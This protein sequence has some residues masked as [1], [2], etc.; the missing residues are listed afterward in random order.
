MG[1]VL[2]EN[3]GGVSYSNFL[4]WI[5]FAI[6][7]VGF[8]QFPPI[9]GSV[10]SYVETIDPEYW[11]WMQ[12]YGPMTESPEA[13]VIAYNERTEGVY[14]YGYARNPHPAD[15]P[16]VNGYVTIWYLDNELFYPGLESSII[17]PNSLY[18]DLNYRCPDAVNG[19]PSWE[20]ITTYAVDGSGNKTVTCQRSVSMPIESPIKMPNANNICTRDPAGRQSGLSTP[21]PISVPSGKKIRFETDYTG[22]GPQPL[23][24]TRGYLNSSIFS[25]GMGPNWWHNHMGSITF[26]VWP[27]A[28]IS[29]QA[30]ATQVA[31]SRTQQFNFGLNRRAGVMLPDG[32]VRFFVLKGSAWSAQGNLDSFKAVGAGYAYKAVDDDVVYNFN[33]KGQMVSVVL[34]NGWATTYSYNDK[35]LLDS[36]TNQ[37]DQSLNFVYDG[38][39]LLLQVTTP[40]GG[41][42]GYGY[43]ALNNLTQVSYPDGSTRSF[44]YENSDFPAA[45]T[46]ISVN[47]SRIA[48]YAYN[49]SGKAISTVGVNGVDSYQI[50]YGYDVGQPW[51]SITDPL[52]ITR[53]YSYGT[54]Y[55]RTA[56]LWA[57]A[58]AKLNGDVISRGQD[59]NTGLITAETDYIG[60]NK[61]YSWDANRF[62]LSSMRETPRYAV[63]TAIRTSS[64]TWHPNYRLPLRDFRPGT[65]LSYVYNGQPDPFNGD[66]IANCTPASAL[67]GEGLPLPVLCKKVEQATTDA[68]G[69]AGVN[70]VVNV[71]VSSR[72]WTWTYN[73]SAQVLTSTDPRG[74]VANYT[75]GS[76]GSIASITNAMGHVTTYLA[77]D[78]NGNPL[79]TSD[80]NGVITNYTYDNR[81]RVASVSVDGQTT[82]YAYTPFGK[83][84]TV[85]MPDGSKITM[86]YDPNLRLTGMTDNLGNSYTYTLDNAGNRIAEQTTGPSGNLTYQISRVLDGL[87]RLQQVTGRE[88]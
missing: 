28:V 70:A 83:L 55:G 4:A 22:A 66:S 21:N 75:Y 78:G 7:C 27:N 77:Y 54:S 47:G 72:I 88:Q 2:F 59:P 81:Q 40:G 50:Y 24:L 10:V 74:S 14:P 9:P 64:S 5:I 1:C 23:T 3:G 17:T 76:L 43:D 35:G 85:N 29:G 67:N 34:S 6:P 87:G 19:E 73:A 82:T 41:A 20:M 42:I 48:T 15:V 39:G 61:I 38:N 69:S 68:D 37:F 49:S 80:P 26:S 31:P 65:L 44:F 46:G 51:N 79:Q 12:N 13:S 30:G 53:S 8:A 18:V 56:V 84:S 16:F 60:T 11:Y 86:S 58:P 25:G 62:L 45:L 52:G 36:V 57:N 33:A 63:D 32:S 71:N